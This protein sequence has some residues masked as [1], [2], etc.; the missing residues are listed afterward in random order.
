[1]TDK[2]LPGAMIVFEKACSTGFRQSEYGVGAMDLSL[3]RPESHYKWVDLGLIQFA[4][5]TQEQLLDAQTSTGFSKGANANADIHRRLS[6]KQ[7]SAINNMIVIMLEK[8]FNGVIPPDDE[9]DEFLKT[10]VEKQKEQP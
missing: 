6:F 3:F 1:M 2:T 10:W 4:S 7:A 8:A 9:M 5:P